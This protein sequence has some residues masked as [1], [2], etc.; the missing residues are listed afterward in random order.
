MANTLDFF[1]DGS[2][3][4]GDQHA[5]ANVIPKGA[6]DNSKT[7]GAHIP[8]RDKAEKDAMGKP[9]IEK[10]PTRKTE[11]FDKSPPQNNAGKFEAGNP[12][13]RKMSGSWNEQNPGQSFSRR[14]AYASPYASGPVFQRS[15]EARDHHANV[16][17]ARE[18]YMNAL[19]ARDMA[20]TF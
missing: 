20:H 3:T 19:L 2:H 14:S 5:N 7:I 18:A 8:T 9:R 4:H 1:S 16:L 11:V 17:M 6:A 15:L 13:T 10:D 12:G